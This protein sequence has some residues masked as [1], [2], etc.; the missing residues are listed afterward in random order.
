[1]ELTDS[2]RIL[3]R[4]RLIAALGVPLIVALAL[5]GT[6]R[7]SLSP[8]GLTPPKQTMG[9]ASVKVL[10]D[11]PKSQLVYLDP[12]VD[13]NASTLPLRARVL[14]DEMAGEGARTALAREFGVPAAQIDVSPFADGPTYT[15]TLAKRVGGA[16]ADGTRPYIVNLSADSK[17]SIVSIDTTAPDGL[18]ASRLAQAAL[19]ALTRLV[20]SE[21]GDQGFVATPLG[22]PRASQFLVGSRKAM[23]A[24]VALFA[25]GLWLFVVVVAGGL[26]LARV[27]SRPR[28]IAGA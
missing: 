12:I 9:I 7:V 10:I 2:L 24:A 4:H 16:N 1:M 22:K 13:E 5:L 15:S 18:Q 6:H 21:G 23:T 8:F 14:A 3:W 26:S 17:R 11:T 27:E 20:E 25:I 19:T 28:Q